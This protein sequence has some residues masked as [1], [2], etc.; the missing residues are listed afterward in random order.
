MF[1]MAGR[2]ALR[3]RPGQAA[4]G[5]ST[6]LAV[7]GYAVIRFVMEGFRADTPAAPDVLTFT[8]WVCL[9]LFAGCLSATVWLRASRRRTHLPP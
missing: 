6:L 9:A 5:Q 4:L 3:L 1:L 2:I 7:G 8:Q